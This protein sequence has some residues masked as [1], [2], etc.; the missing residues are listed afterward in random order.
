MRAG[1]WTLLS[2]TLTMPLSTQWP[3]CAIIP[4][5]G[6][7]MLPAMKAELPLYLAAAAAAPVIDKSDVDTF[8]DALL[9]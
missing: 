1:A 4:L 6:L 8:T 3:P 7:G 9:T 2:F 5:L